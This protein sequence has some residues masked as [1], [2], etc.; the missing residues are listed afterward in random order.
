MGIALAAF[1]CRRSIF[2]FFSLIQRLLTN[3]SVCNSCFVLCSTIMLFP[4]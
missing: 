4:N 2:F 1:V 3:L